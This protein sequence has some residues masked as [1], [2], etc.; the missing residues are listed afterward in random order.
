MVMQ[1]IFAV[2]WAGFPLVAGF[3][4]RLAAARHRL[5]SARWNPAGQPQVIWGTLQHLAL[6]AITLGL[7]LSGIFERALRLNLR[8]ALRSDYVEAARSRGISE[9]RVVLRHALPNALL[10]VLTITGITV[11]SLIGGAL[12]IELIFSWPGIAYR[13]QEAIAQRTIP[14]CRGSW[15]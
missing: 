4:H 9:R 13:L 3:P 14:W 15:W 6:P 10:P 2:G 1:L 11:A 7:L 8:R 12:L 5:L